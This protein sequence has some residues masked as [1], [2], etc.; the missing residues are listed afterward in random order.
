MFKIIHT[1]V[2]DEEAVAMVRN[3]SAVSL[4]P[5]G[6]LDLLSKRQGVW[7]E[8]EEVQACSLSRTHFKFTVC[9]KMGCNTR[10]NWISVFFNRCYGLSSGLK[11]DNWMRCTPSLKIFRMCL[12]LLSGGSRCGAGVCS[13]WS[14]LSRAEVDTK[15]QSHD[16]YQYYNISIQ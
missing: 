1:I 3:A 2:D 6:V 12:L 8:P 16:R 15:G 9:V 10:D 4:K 11:H 5:C 14:C 13:R 7:G